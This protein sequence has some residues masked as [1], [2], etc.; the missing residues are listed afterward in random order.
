MYPHQAPSQW[1]CSLKRREQRKISSTAINYQYG[2]Y[3]QWRP[4]RLSRR[5][6]QLIWQLQ[7]HQ[8]AHLLHLGHLLIGVERK[9][10]QWPSSVVQSSQ[11]IFF[12][13]SGNQEITNTVCHYADHKMSGT[14]RTQCDGAKESITHCMSNQRQKQ[15]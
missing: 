8:N 15:K 6:R 10:H 9:H 2:N 12:E 4:G 7:C 13:F 3:W 14:Q 11:L 5:Q 1:N